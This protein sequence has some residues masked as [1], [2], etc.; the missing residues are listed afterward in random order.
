M[1]SVD[2]ASSAASSFNSEQLEYSEKVSSDLLSFLLSCFTKKKQIDFKLSEVKDHFKTVTECYLIKAFEMLGEKQSIIVDNRSRIVKY[3]LNV[4]N[5]EVKKA[6]SALIKA[7]SSTSGLFSL[8]FSFL[9]H[10]ISF[11]QR[12]KSLPQ[13]RERSKKKIKKMIMTINN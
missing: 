5:G 9:A 11:Q 2:V 3:T 7:T 12:R 10:L 4:N 13:K 6:S 1:T 8:C